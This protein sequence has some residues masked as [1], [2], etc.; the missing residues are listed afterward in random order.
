MS[1]DK[2]SIFMCPMAVTASWGWQMERDDAVAITGSVLDVAEKE[3]TPA[4]ATAAAMAATV[5]MV[6]VEAAA[7]P[8]ATAA[9]AAN[10]DVAEAAPPAAL[11]AALTAMPCIACICAALTPPGFPVMAN[12][13]I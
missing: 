6:A 7:A 12:P 1:S 8:A 2:N 11:P 3:A 9:V 5:A 10:A 4:P 13:P